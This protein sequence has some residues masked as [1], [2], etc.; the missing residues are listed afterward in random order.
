MFVQNVPAAGGH[1]TPWGA[2]Q[3]GAAQLLFLRLHLKGDCRLP[4]AQVLGSYGIATEVHSA[5]GGLQLAPIH[6]PGLEVSMEQA[7]WRATSRSRAGP[8]AA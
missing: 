6:G 1:Y 5:A 7:C 3:Q 8:G 4:N 2:I